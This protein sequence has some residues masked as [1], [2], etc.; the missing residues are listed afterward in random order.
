[1]II[2]PTDSP[3]N[4]D[5]AD[6]EIEFSLEDDTVDQLSGPE[7]ANST[8]AG[9]NGRAA[10]RG[11]DFDRL[12]D[13]AVEKVTDGFSTSGPEVDQEPGQEA[14]QQADQ[15]GAGSCDRHDQSLPERHL[16]DDGNA[17]RVKDRHGQDMRFCHPG[18]SWFAWDGKR[19]AADRSGEAVRRAKDTQRAYFRRAAQEM[20]ALARTEAADEEENRRNARLK[21]LKAAIAHALKWE[22]VKRIAAS[23]E[24]ARPE[25]PVLPEQMDADPWLLNVLNGTLDL[26][27][28]RLR[29]HRRGDLITKLAPVRYDP[30]ARCPLWLKVLERIMDSNSDMVTYLQ[31]SAGYSLTGSVAEQVMWFFYGEGQNG[32]STYLG[33]LRGLLGDYALQAV[34]ELLLSR[35]NEAHPTERADLAGC[36]FVATIETDEGKRMAEALLKQLT[37]GDPVRARKMHQDFFEM[38]PTW[39]LFLAANHKPAVHGCDLA[40]WRR[41]KLV[42]FVVTIPEAE[43]DKHLPEKLKAEWPGILAWAVEGCLAWQ[44]NGLGEPEEVRQA[45]DAYRAEQDTVGGFINACCFLH[46]S[47]KVKAS[48]LWEAYVSWSGDKFMTLKSF[49]ERMEEKGYSNK[50]GTGGAYFWGGIG[51]AEGAK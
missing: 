35:K 15:D 44:R 41:I 1:M 27:T 4:P 10:A 45:T 46:P 6:I 19:W 23:L 49:G 47:V 24:L 40:V 38:V 12:I 16:T 39:K 36:R 9:G 26:R 3:G 42:P 50:R 11:E 14:D 13:E 37:G 33:T 2:G 18:K 28:G 21:Q 31:R 34:S 8:A 7:H 30:R 29:P 25:L 32:K 48:A 20:E 51:L 43:R 22:D 5:D 17:L